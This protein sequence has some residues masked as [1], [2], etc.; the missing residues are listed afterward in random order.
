MGVEEQVNDKI[1]ERVNKVGLSKR[2]LYM[3]NLLFKYI[4]RY[5]V[6]NKNNNKSNKNTN[7]NNKKAN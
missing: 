3:V 6:N 2:S 1:K 4:G 7:N 5:E